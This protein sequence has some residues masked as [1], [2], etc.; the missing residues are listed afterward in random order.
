MK[1]YL[2]RGNTWTP[3][4]TVTEDDEAYDCTGYTAKLWIKQTL[5]ETAAEIAE[6][7]ISWTDQAGGVG[8]FNLTHAQ[9]AAM[10]GRYWYEVILYETASNTVVKTLIQ[11]RLIVR[12][13]LEADL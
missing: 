10:T 5:K 3:T 7:T 1:K 13:T 8:Y 6:L 2:K 12:E 9:S 11:N 4:L